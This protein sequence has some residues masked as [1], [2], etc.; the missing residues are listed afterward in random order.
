MHA[1]LRHNKQLKIYNKAHISDRLMAISGGGMILCYNGYNELIE[2][3]D[4]RSIKKDRQSLQAS[5]RDTQQLNE[6]LIREI[7]ANNY[8]RFMDDIQ[9]EKGVL[10]RIHDDDDQYRMDT[11]E[12]KSMRTVKNYLGRSF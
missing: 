3:H 2:L 11:L 5:F 7:K 12:E 9:E 6:Y 8:R 10:Q 4:A 1:V